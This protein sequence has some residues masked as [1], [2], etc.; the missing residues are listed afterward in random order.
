MKGFGDDVMRQILGSADVRTLLLAAKA[1]RRL[2]A[3]ARMRG[4]LHE[5]VLN[6]FPGMLDLPAAQ[7]YYHYV[8]G[9]ARYY[10]AYRMG[11]RRSEFDVSSSIAACIAGRHP[12]YKPAPLQGIL[13]SVMQN[14]LWLFSHTDKDRRFVLARVK[15]WRASCS[16]YPGHFLS[17]AVEILDAISSVVVSHFAWTPGGDIRCHW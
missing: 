8:G 16:L 7:D 6:T 2:R 4:V 10:G 13:K 14:G 5:A 9:L 17:N 12:S 1:C 3:L 11:F 15:D